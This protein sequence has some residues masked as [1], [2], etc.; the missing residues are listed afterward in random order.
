VIVLKVYKVFDEVFILMKNL[1][2]NLITARLPFHP[3]T[4]PDKSSLT[5]C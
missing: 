3:P 2:K 5:L 4:N 1:V